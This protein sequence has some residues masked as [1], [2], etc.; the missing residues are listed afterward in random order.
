MCLHHT[1]SQERTHAL[2]ASP[3]SV[4]PMVDFKTR[5]R[6]EASCRDPTSL[7]PPAGWGGQLCQA[8][9]RIQQEDSVSLPQRDLSPCQQ[10]GGTGGIPDTTRPGIRGLR[11]T[12]ASMLIPGP[13][14]R[15]AVC[16]CR[17]HRLCVLPVTS[18]QERQTAS[19][20][21]L[22]LK[23][24]CPSSP[25]RNLLRSFKLYFWPSFLWQCFLHQIW[26]QSRNYSNIKI[27]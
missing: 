12:R 25:N 21:P 13:Q 19:L 23:D 11:E 7:R 6:W 10:S 24:S 27:Y 2:A 18:S 20:K 17:S 9:P 16:C 15:E 5:A 3:S 14:T 22:F 1:S 4:A 26:R 8:G